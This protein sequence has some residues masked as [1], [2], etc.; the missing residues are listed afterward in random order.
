MSD[1]ALNIGFLCVLTDVFSWGVDT[2]KKIFHFHKLK[3]RPNKDNN[4]IHWIAVVELIPEFSLE[5]V[6]SY[7][8]IV[9]RLF[10]V[11]LIVLL[12]DIFYF[13]WLFRRQVEYFCC[14]A[15]FPIMKMDMF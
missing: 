10:D 11:K 3:V 4:F 6:K 9:F 2:G 14:Y 13:L 1:S 15:A 8:Q 7:V 12:L 5:K